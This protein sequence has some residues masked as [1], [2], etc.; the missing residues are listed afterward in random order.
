MY[1]SG[2]G[3]SAVPQAEKQYNIINK[4]THRAPNR[5]FLIL[6]IA[7]FIVFLGYYS[8]C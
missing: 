6:G 5:S 1:G 4:Q 2:R 7:S 3:G 8:H